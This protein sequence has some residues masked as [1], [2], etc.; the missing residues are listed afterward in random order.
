LHGEFT[1]PPIGEILCGNTGKYA[2]RSDRQANEMFILVES[3]C[4]NILA[5]LGN[6]DNREV[7]RN[8]LAQAVVNHLVHL[9][10]QKGM[11]WAH[12]RA[13][14]G[15][16]PFIVVNTGECKIPPLHL[17]FLPPKQNLIFMNMDQQYQQQKSQLSSLLFSRTFIFCPKE[18]FASS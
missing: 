4:C 7:S 5:L 14:P 2:L 6:I 10:H 1:L 8:A 13:P 17:C 16:S 15:L 18:P 12:Y 11:Q 3:R 9:N